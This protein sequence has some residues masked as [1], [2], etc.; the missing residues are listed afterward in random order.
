MQT[1]AL[2][3]LFHAK[4]S[5]ADIEVGSI[6]HQEFTEVFL[7]DGRIVIRQEPEPGE[8]NE[9]SILPQNAEELARIISGALN[10]I[11]NV[12]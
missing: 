1:G 12:E 5:S 11:G 9:I 3:G 8:V 4:M 10:V 7:R 2:C 6:P